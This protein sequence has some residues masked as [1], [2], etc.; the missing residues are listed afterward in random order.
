MTHDISTGFLNMQYFTFITS[1]TKL[2]PNVIVNNIYD[3]IIYVSSQYIIIGKN[4][5]PPYL[6]YFTVK[7]YDRSLW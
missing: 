5:R 1:C 4:P 7:T 3:D 6:H 2:I